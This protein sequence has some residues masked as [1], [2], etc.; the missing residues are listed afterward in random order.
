MNLN[1]FFS[2]VACFCFCLFVCL[3]LY[4]RNHCQ[5][6]GHEDLPLCFRLGALWLALIFKYLIYFDLIFTYDMR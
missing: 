6:K 3:V 2:S 1:L 5:I 4:V